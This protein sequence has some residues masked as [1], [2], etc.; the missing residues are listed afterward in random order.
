MPKEIRGRGMEK[1]R[2][3]WVRARAEEYRQ[4]VADDLAELDRLLGP[5]LLG[6]LGN[7]G[8]PK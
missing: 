8:V 1:E 6:N 2:A 5:D 4:K 7:E 3:E